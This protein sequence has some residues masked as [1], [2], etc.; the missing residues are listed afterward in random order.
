MNTSPRSAAARAFVRSLNILLKFARMYDFGHPRT[1]AQYDTAWH[2]LR[3]ALGPDDEAGL[4]LS[5]SGDQLLLDGVALESAAAEKS[6]ARM[7]SAAGIASIHFAPTVTQAS[8]ARLVKAFP[9]GG[10]KPAVLAAQLKDAL[11]GDSSIHINE[12]CF[13]PADSAVAKG[14]MAASLAA[15]TLGMESEKYNDLFQD[16]QKLLQMLTAAEGERGAGRGGNAGSGSG[17]GFGSGS[18]SGS[19]SG[20]GRG[21]SGDSHGDGGARGSSG[22]SFSNEASGLMSQ[23][24][25]FGLSW[26]ASGN[27][28]TME[29][30]DSSTQNPTGNGGLRLGS[31]GRA[32]SDADVSAESHHDLSG[33]RSGGRTTSDA[34]VSAKWNRDS[35]GRR[36]GGRATSDA[37]TS[38]RSSGEPG[39]R[40]T[41]A[42]ASLRGG[43]EGG[44]GSDAVVLEAGLIGLQQEELQGI[45]KMLTQIARTGDSDARIDS[46]AFQSR[47]A[48]LP[49]RARFTLTQALAGIASQAPSDRPDQSTLLRLAEH[50]AIRFALESYE[51]GD[52]Q[53]DAVRQMLDSMGREIDGLRKILTQHEDKLMRVGVAV[54]PH[55]EILAQQFWEE[56][57]QEKRNEVLLSPNAWCIP[58]RS[59]QQS[60]DAL[61]QKG[62]RETAEKILENYAH[63]IRSEQLE[64]RRAT[65]LGIA[66]LASFYGGAGERLFVATIREV[67][68]QLSEEHDSELQ[69]VVGAAFVRLAQEAG[70]RRSYAAMQ[71][72]VEMVDFIQTERPGV[73]NSIRPRI[74][75]ENRL[76]EFIDDAL[77]IGKINPGLTAFLRRIPGPSA[78]VLSQR[79]SRSGFREDS[80]LMLEA[81]RTLGPESI[82]HLR[83]TLRNAPAAQAVDTV[84]ML[85]RLDLNALELL[86]PDRLKEWK[87]SAHDRV[88]RQLASSDAPERGHLLLNIFDALDPLVQPLAIDEIGLAG[89][90][91]AEAQL[92]RIADGDLPHG[93]TAYLQLKAIEALGRLRTAGADRILRRIVEGKKVW[94]W[95]FP[96]ELRI[97][98]AQALEKIDP[99]WAK[100]FLPKSGLGVAELALQPLDIETNS[101][102]IRQR[103]Y[104]RLRLE[105]PMNAVTMNL[106][107]NCTIEIP[108]MNLG[109]GVALSDQRLHP[110]TVVALRLNPNQKSLR[111]QAIVRD[112]NTQARAFEVVDMDLEDRAK[113]RRLLVHIGSILK[114]TSPDNR[115]RNRTRTLLSTPG[116]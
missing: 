94:S 97:V 28:S 42:T 31:G 84:A 66:E 26:F 25:D 41:S 38:S 15:R 16:P 99:E 88:V 59:V 101:N 49:R 8:L 43:G 64:A 30:T 7:L 71:R 13:V 20:D 53:I 50:I 113:L 18:G 102:V 17:S 19:G 58:P 6:F 90:H 96:S 79:F 44:G 10:S 103:R 62:D 2:E 89:E 54:R 1:V 37:E 11:D 80:E 12:V 36:S 116:Q 95:T 56:V 86:L 22:G 81:M 51:R 29:G 68:L 73:A 110:G 23:A 52:T 77:K 45:L 109:G 60:L 57:P 83:E 107:E 85:A 32:T 78:E 65:A 98:A 63:C 69:S 100:D 76:A 33:R 75:V 48:S 55:A 87:R 67:G 5:A 47:L 39:G 21:G 34:D 14:H 46:T 91:E 27:A 114:A 3:A 106:K 115:N 35:R 61:Q 108:E 93:A 70:H 4:L 82:T 92:M 112:A 74:A 111:A 24:P 40:W 72:A 105:R 9:T 104:P